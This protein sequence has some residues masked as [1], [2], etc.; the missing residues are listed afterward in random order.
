[1]QRFEWFHR[2]CNSRTKNSARIQSAGQFSSG[3]LAIF[4]LL[5]VAMVTAPA[6]AQ[7]VREW[8]DPIGGSYNDILNWS[9]LDVPDTVSESAL[10]NINNN[11]IVTLNSGATTLV[12]DLLIFDGDVRFSASGSVS[13]TYEIDD[14]ALISSGNLTLN[15]VLGDVTL[16]VGDRMQIIGG[17]TV[18]VLQGSAVTA[19]NLDLAIIGSDG[20]MIVDGVGSTLAVSTLTQLGSGGATGTLTFQ[21]GSTGNSLSGS[22][23]LMANSSQAGSTGRLNV[24]SG[25]TLQAGNINVGLSP[26]ASAVQEATLTVDGVGSTL[27]MNGASTF[28]IGDDI[29]PNIVSDVIVSNSAVMSTGTGAILVQNS[30]YLDVQTGTFN[31]NG[32]LTINGGTITRG[33]DPDGFNLAAGLTLTAQNFA[34]LNFAG[35]Y[36]I[37]QG[38]TFDLQSSADFSTAGSLNIGDSGDGTLLVDGAGSSV[39]VGADSIWGANG[40][41]ANVTFRNGATGALG[42]THIAGTTVGEVHGNLN[43]ESG[44]VVTA[45]TL[46]LAASGGITTSGTITVDGVGSS[47]AQEGSFDLVVGHAT[48]GTATINIHNGGTFSTGTNSTTVNAT[49]TINI[50]NDIGNPSGILNVTSDLTVDGG[51]I[52]RG[53]STN[54]FN[55]TPG[56]TLTAKND[57]QINFGSGYNLDQGTTFDIQSG[58]DFITSDYLDIGSNGNGTLLVDGIGSSVTTGF[59]SYIWGN[60]GNTADV[61]FRNGA[62]GNLGQIFLANSSVSGTTGIFRVESGAAVLANNLNVAV[63]GGNTTGGTLIVNGVGSSLTQNGGSSLTIGHAT[64]GT[65]IVSV[66]NSGTFTTGT[67][68]TTVNAT[69]IV[70]VITAGTFNLL[71]NLD[72]GGTIV[73]QDGG[74]FNTDTGLTTVNGSGTINVGVLGSGDFNANGNLTI[75]GGTITRGGDPDGFNLAAGLTLTTQNFAQLNFAGS[76]SIDQGTTFDLQSSA[77]FDT[78][79][80]LDIGDSGGDGTLIVA[81]LGSRVTT[82]NASSWGSSGNT[83]DVTFRATAS[84]ILSGISLANDTTSGTTGNFNVESGAIVTVGNLDV[85]ASGGITTSGTI[86]IDGVGSSLAQEGSFDLVVGH[87]TEG[88]A[89]INVQNGGTFTTGSETTTVNATGTINVGVVGLGTLNITSDLTVDG[90]TIMSGLNTS[91]L[92]LTP[93]NTLIAKNNGQINLGGAY[94]LNDG[95]TFDFQSGADFITSDYLD[96]GSNSNGTL[97]VDGIGSSVTVG[98]G[99]LSVS[100]WGYNGSTADVTFR[101]GATGDLRKINLANSSVSG[102]TGIFRI[103]SGATVTTDSLHI[104]SGGG[105]TT[106]GTLIVN[107]V[108][109]SLTQNGGSSLTIGHA[110]SGTAIVSVENSGTFTTGTGLT[111]VNATGIVQVITAGT[112]N[113]LG[114]LDLDGTINIVGGTLSA[115]DPVVTGGTWNFAFGT[116]EL[117]SNQ[118]LDSQRLVE[119]DVESLASGKTF[120]VNGATTLL[121]PLTLAGGTFATESLVNAF[122][123]DFQAGTFQLTGDN[124]VVGPAGLFGSSLTVAA[125][126]T[127]D[128][129]N[130][131][132]VENGAMLAIVSGGTFRAGTFSNNG[133]V[134]GDGTIESNFTNSA[135]GEVRLSSNQSLNL[136]GATNINAGEIN[137]FGGLVEFEQ[138]ITNEA[139]GFVGGRGQFVADGGWTNNGVMAFSGT[140]DVLGDIINDSG[141]QIVT[142]GGATTTIFDDLVHNGTEIR[143]SAGSNTVVFGAASGAGPY[144]GTGTVFFEGD[145]RP[146]NSPGVVDFAGDVV[147]GST[148]KTEIELTGA[149]DGLYDQL[150]VANTITL[151]GI[152]DVTLLDGFM[153]SAGDTFEIVQAAGGVAGMFSTTAEEL[154]TLAENLAWSIN[155]GSNNVVIEIIYDGLA[156]DY[157]NDGVVNLA[158]YTV[159]RDNLGAAAG[160]LV[161]DANTGVI[162]VAQYST[163]KTN[164]GATLPPVTSLDNATVPEPSTCVFLTLSAVVCACRYRRAGN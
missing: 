8:I 29:N 75:N 160:S 156:G 113:L 109:S 39:T 47:L 119:L 14:D 127:F 66:E 1:M 163:W 54:G 22:V 108:G 5:L 42:L 147:L 98:G 78:T 136:T 131:A 57:A 7:T 114:D 50:S 107:G 130:A 120:R 148:L 96:V 40:S 138:G 90:G 92:N 122:L 63:L 28:T 25:S 153:P 134:I 95:T 6:K 144:T 55:L 80:S 105:N 110:T 62:M 83:A 27:S 36:S 53:L 154:P 79:S 164:F 67:G 97:V 102:T 145:L 126:Q 69:G 106:G 135:S 150:D 37:D 61:T 77:D 149:S 76:Y 117:N 70:Q 17:S 3:V 88:T 19:A 89:T 101:N 104:A 26:S 35:S 59:S 125:T 15:Q 71:G 152:L 30:G 87:A 60:S 48:E 18:S 65:A 137:N 24:L 91:G 157:N 73:L 58:A 72:L 20:T 31:A 161:N 99:V 85:A 12:S 103:E 143:T 2:Q 4:A 139:S 132:T 112:F 64:S 38:T 86:T 32:N 146:G 159:W 74:V 23:D 52:T 11:Y 46:T 141:G 162:G 33:G 84:G 94:S 111:T 21:N 115:V 158:D 9:T 44:A 100:L 140:T 128:I 121:T 10:F 142:S 81:D 118:A 155:Y 43:V 49:G 93:G 116:V 133:L 129:S 82:G 124:L 45:N 68:L 51:T 123:L 34:Q 56:N 13:A 41:T 151:D 16:N